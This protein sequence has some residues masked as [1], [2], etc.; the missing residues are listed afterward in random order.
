MEQHPTL[1]RT[2]GLWPIVLLGL[3]YLTPAVVFDTFGLVSKETSGYVPTA[4]V[5]TLVAMLF[6]AYSYGKMV[7]AYP[8]A[9]SAY[10]YAQ[11]SINPQVGFFV[12]WLALLDYLL[13][14]LINVLL[15]QQYIT[16]IFPDVPPWIWVVLITAVV[17]YFNLISM[18]STSTVNSIFV[19]YQFAILVVFIVLSIKELLGGMGYGTPLSMKPFMGPDMHFST[20]VSGATILCF[21]FLGFDAVSTYTEEAINPKKTI[22]RAIFLTALIGGGLFIVA[23][24][25]TQLLYPDLSMFKD[26]E[27]STASDISYN[28]GG[29]LFQILFLSAS[30]AGIFASGL[31]SHASVSRL[32]YVM[33][34]DNVLPKKFFGYI[35][36]KFRT[37]AFN[38]IFVGIICLGAIFFTVET[39]TEFINFGSL[40]AFTFVNISVIAH[41]AIRNK[42]YKSLKQIFF[43]II[44]PLIGSFTV[45]ILWLNVQKDSF[46]LGLVW[47]A[48]GV[49]YLLF[50]TKVLKVSADK[51]MVENMD[52]TPD[53][54]SN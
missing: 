26:I 48:I 44:L 46:I 2:L 5:L 8:T 6:T 37:P 13:L 11:R 1:K 9:G 49:L 23:S 3:G 22:P 28:I 21:S 45:F 4:Y 15:G 35:H 18:K 19:I 14:P 42:E 51:I 54:K 31:A 34:R 32:L 17:T 30:F 52:D 39:A 12:G 50:L 27:N 16:A 53:V 24:Y 29:K 36:P 43:N 7:N 25:F 20:L 40:I 41:Y 47:A 38:V 10:T 33:G